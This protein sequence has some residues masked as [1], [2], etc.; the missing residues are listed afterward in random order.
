MPLRT[1]SEARV[2]GALAICMTVLT[3]RASRAVTD[4]EKIACVS[5]SAQGQKLRRAARLID[6]R[7]AFVACAQEQCPAIVKRDCTE[8]LDA[9][10]ASLPS[11]VLGAQTAD[12]HDAVGANLAIDGVPVSVN[13]A[14]V[15]IDPG[16]HRCRAEASGLVVEQTVMVRE[17]EKNRSVI[18]RFGGASGDA[19]STPPST[20]TVETRPVPV[21][22][23][24]FAA[25]G[26]GAL[27]SFAYFGARGV[28]DRGALDGCAP[29]CNRSQV[30]AVDTK[31]WIADVSLGVS[32][33][34]LG[35]ATWT[36]LTRPA[37]R[38]PRATQRGLAPASAAAGWWWSGAP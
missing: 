16:L 5:A 18:L 17:G 11:L 13:G 9:V 6:A 8:W 26:V 22:V 24:V 23:Y 38:E 25:I 28:S 33:V 37:A 19:P 31:F 20:P 27:G 2:A 1:I 30:N 4:E 35:V 12:G 34:A 32:I 10:D 21:L 29:S 15:P 36:F 3:P 14:A 7:K